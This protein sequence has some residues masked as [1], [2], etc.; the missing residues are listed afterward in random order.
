MIAYHVQPSLVDFYSLAR[1]KC[2]L[3]SV[4]AARGIHC[5]SQSPHE[6]RCSPRRILAP[7]DGV[8]QGRADDHAVCQVAHGLSLRRRRDS[9]TDRQWNGCQLAHALDK[10]L[11]TRRQ[12]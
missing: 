7:L 3:C 12:G 9:E 6:I 11:Q 2:R 5:A 8:D 10:R 1:L 4:L